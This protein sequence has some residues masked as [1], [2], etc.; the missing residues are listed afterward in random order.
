MESS[1][2]TGVHVRGA[3]VGEEV[4]RVLRADGTA[5][6]ALD[7]RLDPEQ[8]RRIYADMVAT[9]LD[10]YAAARRAERLSTSRGRVRRLRSSPPR[11]PFGRTT[12]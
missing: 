10:A 8:L 4:I 9:I 2:V 7:P 3:G 1:Q 12:G 11:P 5:E 6:H